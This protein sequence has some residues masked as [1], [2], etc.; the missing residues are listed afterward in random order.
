MTMTAGEVQASWC[1]RCHHMIERLPHAGWAH[2]S[3]DDWS[4][5]S[6]P[7]ACRLTRCTPEQPGD[8]RE[9]AFFYRRGWGFIRAS[10]AVTGRLVA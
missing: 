6:C 1:A 4:E 7:C 9:P 2:A 10:G 8:G 5:N 3:D